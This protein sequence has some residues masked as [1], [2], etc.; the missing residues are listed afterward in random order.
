MENAITFIN[1]TCDDLRE[2]VLDVYEAFFDDN[3]D[4]IPLENGEQIINALLDLRNK[5]DEVIEQINLS[6]NTI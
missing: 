6:S 5:T 4:P 1:Y 2:K 3:G